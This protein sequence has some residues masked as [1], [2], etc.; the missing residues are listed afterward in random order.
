MWF[1]HLSGQKREHNMWNHKHR[2]VRD[3]YLLNIPLRSPQKDF[4]FSKFLLAIVSF[5]SKNVVI[6]AFSR[7]GFQQ[8]ET[9]LGSYVKGTQEHTRTHCESRRQM[10]MMR[11]IVRWRNHYKCHA[12][13][14]LRQRWPFLSQVWKKPTDEI[15]HV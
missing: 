9:G 8:N 4:G 15:S 13:S 5:L 1:S 11:W 7:Q 6:I 10:N 2:D 3:T 14:S 12:V